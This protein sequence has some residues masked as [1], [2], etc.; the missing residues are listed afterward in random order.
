LLAIAGLFFGIA[1]IIQFNWSSKNKNI[2][3]P[4]SLFTLQKTFQLISVIVLLFGLY[5][6][7]TR[8]TIIIG[9]AL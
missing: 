5:V 9:M 6:L 8:G 4:T 1:G 7:A 3:L 2:K